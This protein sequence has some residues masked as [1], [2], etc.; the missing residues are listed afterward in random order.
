MDIFAIPT[1]WNIF[2]EAIF[3]YL[4]GTNPYNSHYGLF[5]PPWLIPIYLPFALFPFG[6]ELLF[7]AT[8][9]GLM[10]IAYRL[11][12]SPRNVVFILTPFV[13]AALLWGNIEWI[14][15]LGL[16]VAPSFGLVLLALKPQMTLCVILFLVIQ[17]WQMGGWRTTVKLLLPVTLLFAVSVIGFGFWFMHLFDYAGYAARHFSAFPWL[18]PLGVLLF[19]QSIRTQDIR[20]ALAASPMFFDNLSP[21]VWLVVPLALVSST[22]WSIVV[23]FS[24]WVVIF[25]IR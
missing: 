22:R 17:S 16:V 9:I 3:A 10:Y 14:A 23:W 7:I 12:P 24:S 6:R 11:H 1:D 4:N 19:R 18:V 5:N 25:V 8:L 21:Q 13:I 20:Y 15:L 2:R